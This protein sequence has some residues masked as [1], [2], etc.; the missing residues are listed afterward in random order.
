MEGE[1]V[2]VSSFQLQEQRGR[3][4]AGGGDRLVVCKKEAGREE[5]RGTKLKNSSPPVVSSYTHSVQV[6][7]CLLPVLVLHS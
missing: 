7:S 6:D 3:R 1:A 5:K 2:A 4:E